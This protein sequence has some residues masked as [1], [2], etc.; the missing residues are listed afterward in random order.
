MALVRR[1]ISS[2]KQIVLTAAVVGLFALTFGLAY[3]YLFKKPPVSAISEEELIFGKKNDLTA[4]PPQRS[5]LNALEDLNKSSTARG[6]KKFGNWPLP[7]EPHGRADLFA[8]P[9]ADEE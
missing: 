7:V 3:I 9:S 1:K 5:G 6:L 8:A 4:P 2:K